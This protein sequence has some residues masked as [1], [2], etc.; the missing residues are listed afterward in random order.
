MLVEAR[1]IPFS[2]FGS[3]TLK[4]AGLQ[5]FDEFGKAESTLT[6]SLAAAITLVVTSLLAQNLPVSD[7]PDNGAIYSYS[8]GM[9]AA[10]EKLSTAT[11]PLIRA[12]V[13]AA[14]AR[15]IAAAASGSPSAT[16]RADLT[17]VGE[18]EMPDAS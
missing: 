13:A 18:E 11:G 6:A 12:R 1:L 3:K 14:N 2:F 17:A 7:T 9:T 5:P 15:A 8:K 16:P 4:N 10:I